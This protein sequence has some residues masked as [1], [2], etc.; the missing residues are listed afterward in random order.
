MNEKNER[1]RKF[2]K[3][4][5]INEKASGTLKRVMVFI[6]SVNWIE[7]DCSYYTILKLK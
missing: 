1:E 6:S 2:I 5:K 4:H 3:V 7:P